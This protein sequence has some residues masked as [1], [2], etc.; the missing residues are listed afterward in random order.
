VDSG[1][2]LN[3]DEELPD[4]VIESAKLKA[5]LILEIFKT[6]GIDA[7]NVGELDLVLGLDYLKEL[8]KKH[9]FPFVSTNLVDADNKPVFERYVLKQVNGKTVAIMG[10]YGDTSEMAGKLADITGGKLTVQDPIKAAEAV[11]AELAGKADYVIAMTHQIANRD[12]VIAR[13]VKGV[14][15]VVGGH[16]RQK[17]PDPL[18]AGDAL[19]VR[20]GEKGQYLGM[21]EVALDGS[22]EPA[23]TLV[24][25]DESIADD[26]KV[27][28]MI[29]AY[30]DKVADM[31]G[32]GS[33][34]QP[35]AADVPLRVEACAPCHSSQVAQ[36]KTT[37]HAK[38]YATLVGKSKQYDPKCLSCHTIRF[39]QPGGFNMQEMQMAFVNVQCESCHGDATEHLA[40]MKPIPVADPQID[41]CLKCHTDDRCPEFEE[42]KEIVFDKIRH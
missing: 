8:E 11:V 34:D 13:R 25:F 6:I 40:S 32:G 29:S 23:N 14:H 27:Q 38:A 15:L 4:S 28:E 19:I 37:D 31:Y 7:V 2:L 33:G 10:L 5:E 1:D 42:E 18:V 9:S 3:E 35:A 17:T 39:E 21:L 30:N 26:G 16:D 20:A 36:W 41:L 22:K 12:W 24:A